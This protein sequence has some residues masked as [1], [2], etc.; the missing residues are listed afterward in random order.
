MA[1]RA[2]GAPPETARERRNRRRR[3]ERA[4]DKAAKA[5]GHADQAD[6]AVDAPAD[7]EVADGVMIALDRADDGGFS[8][9]GC[10]AF[11]DVRPAEVPIVLEAAVAFERK[12]LGLPAL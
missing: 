4:A 8:I 9:R 6:G 1:A 5:N 3:E 11:G 2:K 7:V 12:R 10:P